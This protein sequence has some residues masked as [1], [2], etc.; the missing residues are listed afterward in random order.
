MAVAPV[1]SGVLTKH[2]LV[3]NIMSFLT[4]PELSL[5]RLVCKSWNEASAK[6]HLILQLFFN[7]LK[8]EMNCSAYKYFL[9]LT[10][11]E[12]KTHI[13]RCLQECSQG[14]NWLL[15]MVPYQFNGLTKGTIDEKNINIYIEDKVKFS[16]Y[17][18]NSYILNICS[19]T[20]QKYIQ[21]EGEK[22]I[23][24]EGS[25]IEIPIYEQMYKIQEAFNQKLYIP[26]KLIMYK[27]H[28]QYT[29]PVKA[30]I[31]FV[32]MTP[33]HPAEPIV[34]YFD[35]CDT[36]IIFN[37]FGLETMET[38]IVDI[39]H[40]F[41][42]NSRKLLNLMNK[43]RPEPSLQP[44]YPLLIGF[45]HLMPIGIYKINIKQRIGFRYSLVKYISSY[46]GS[47][48]GDK[49][50]QPIQCYNFALRGTFLN[51][52]HPL[53]PSI[54]YEE[55]SSPIL[56]TGIGGHGTCQMCNKRSYALQG[57]KFKLGCTH[58]T[59]TDCVVQ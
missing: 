44:V 14:A 33:I 41:N 42:L 57:N 31:I 21:K 46:G 40:E 54:K 3:G 2:Y 20:I 16:L 17:G 25:K 30:L 8:I 28:S 45:L 34:K 22:N 11:Q 38:R 56:L 58:I 26:E 10:K 12:K 23:K 35:N 37:S 36:E 51:F 52:A 53:I 7:S 29:H 4:L 59:C 50:K 27:L 43:D 55:M 13:R 15:P 1:P 32:S 5:V 24:E 6:C 49:H 48:A 9:E 18:E 19:P 47:V 39:Y